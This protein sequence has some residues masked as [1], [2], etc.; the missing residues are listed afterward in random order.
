[1]VS[2]KEGSS[3][4]SSTSTTAVGGA[5]TALVIVVLWRRCRHCFLR[6]R[7]GLG[8]RAILL[9]RAS[10]LA[11]LNHLIDVGLVL[12]GH[13]GVLI[14]VDAQIDVPILALVLEGATHVVDELLA[15]AEKPRQRHLGLPVAPAADQLLPKIEELDLGE[16]QLLEMEPPAAGHIP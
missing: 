4:A 10:A 7:Y 11:V 6:R 5:V 14:V 15:H 8:P 2:G 13:L 1:M 16:R 12:L 9:R 3:G